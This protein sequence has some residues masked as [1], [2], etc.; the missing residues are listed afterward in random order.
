MRVLRASVPVENHRVTVNN[1]T[2]STNAIGECDWLIRVGQ[3]Y[4]VTVE[5]L[6]TVTFIADGPITWT[7]YLPIS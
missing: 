7:F 6:P 3:S 4:T 2:I 5:T 1:V